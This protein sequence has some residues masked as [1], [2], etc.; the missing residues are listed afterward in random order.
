MANAPLERL[1][2]T[3]GSYNTLSAKADT[4][5]VRENGIHNTISI[6]RVMLVPYNAQGNGGND[7][8]SETR[9]ASNVSNEDKTGGISCMHNP[10][11]PNATQCETGPN[12][13]KI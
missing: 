6:E 9:K 2:K 4:I 12:W 7:R 11:T 13:K 5:T 1:P 8:D 10:G 3:L